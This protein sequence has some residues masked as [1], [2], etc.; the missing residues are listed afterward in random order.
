MEK[1]L[2]L[3]KEQEQV[4]KTALRAADELRQAQSGP[5]KNMDYQYLKNTV[6]KLITTGESE[7][8][9]PVLAKLLNFTETEVESLTEEIQ[10]SSK[11]AEE[12][13]STVSLLPSFTGWPW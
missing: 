8:L 9:L 6:M 1:E 13:T 12:L 7:A 2:Q 3:H 10:K 11:K 4:L 5:P